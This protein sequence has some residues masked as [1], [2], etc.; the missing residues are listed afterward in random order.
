MS[1]SGKTAAMRF[2]FNLILGGLFFCFGFLVAFWSYGTINGG[3]LFFAVRNLTSVALVVIAAN[4][5]VFVLSYLT[6][7]VLHDIKDSLGL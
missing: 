4:A 1:V 6:V 7:S 2:W 3:G 5:N